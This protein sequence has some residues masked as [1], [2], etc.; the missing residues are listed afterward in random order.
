MQTTFG[1]IGS[2]CCSFVAKVQTESKDRRNANKILSVMDRT[3]D[4]IEKLHCLE[5]T[6]W[7]VL[8]DNCTDP[9]ELVDTVTSYVEFCEETVSKT[10]SVHVYPNNK[11]WVIQDLKVHLNQKKLAFL[12]GKRE[13]YIKKQ[14][15]EFRKNARAAR[16]RYKNKVEEKFRTGN[17]REAWSGLRAMMGKQQTKHSLPHSANSVDTANE[18]NRFYARFDVRDFSENCAT[19]C[20]TVVPEQLDLSETDVVTSFSRLNSHKASGSDGLKGRT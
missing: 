16:L 14:E 6:N 20:E 7:D 18:I 8:T 17:A 2:Q 10:K 5:M 3:H 19:L 11:P 13:E 1:T 12:K 9:D 15:K 4:S